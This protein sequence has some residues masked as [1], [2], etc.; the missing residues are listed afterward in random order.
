MVP[1]V[2]DISKLSAT[3]ARQFYTLKHSSARV[4][5][6]QIFSA[7]ASRESEMV[8]TAHLLNLMCAHTTRRSTL[9]ARRGNERERHDSRERWRAPSDGARIG[10]R[11]RWSVGLR[12]SHSSK[13]LRASEPQRARFGRCASGEETKR[14]NVAARD[15][16]GCRLGVRSTAS[17]DAT[18]LEGDATRV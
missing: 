2:S 7:M 15:S 11:R 8:D 1:L 5:L 9:E 4:L 18:R 12:E 17:A 13:P 3:L 16:R 6:C 10:S 14:E